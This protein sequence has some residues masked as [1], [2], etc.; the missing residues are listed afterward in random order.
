MEM[1]TFT[2]QELKRAIDLIYWALSVKD[3]IEM[4]AKVV[5]VSSHTMKK[6]YYGQEYPPSWHH[7]KI[8]KII[9]KANNRKKLVENL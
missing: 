6:W 3:S 9:R 2:Q 5:G 4:A 1:I 7:D 8:Y